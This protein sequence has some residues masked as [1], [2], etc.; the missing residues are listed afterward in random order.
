M[1]VG[2]LGTAVGEATSFV[3]APWIERNYDSNDGWRGEPTLGV[4]QALFRGDHMAM[5]A[6]AGALWNS[7]PSF[8]E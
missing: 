8:S 3:V 2:L 6:P 1:N 4:K 7:H 5:A